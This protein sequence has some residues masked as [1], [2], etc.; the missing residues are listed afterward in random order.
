M[1]DQQPGTSRQMIFNPPS[2]L[3]H[4]RRK[5]NTT[6][7]DYPVSLEL[8]QVYYS[9]SRSTHHSH[10]HPLNF[11][12]H[13]HQFHLPLIKNSQDPP[14]SLASRVSPNQRISTHKS[15]QTGPFKGHPNRPKTIIQLL[16]PKNKKRT[17]SNTYTS[18]Q[19]TK[20]CVNE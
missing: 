17:P 10:F 12:Q 8:F 14:A 9:T 19:Y 6:L 5:V 16:L 3:L 13:R 7:L 18:P 1:D 20:N 11:N 4:N 15:H 2:L